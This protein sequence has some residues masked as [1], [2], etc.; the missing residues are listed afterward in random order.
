MNRIKDLG[1]YSNLISAE[2]KANLYKTYCRP[3]LYYGIE[4]LMMTEIE[5]KKLQTTEANI[6]KR[7]FELSSKVKTTNLI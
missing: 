4:N 7:S 5:K 6:V 1:I 3:I 2:M